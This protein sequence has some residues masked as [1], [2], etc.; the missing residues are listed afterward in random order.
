MSLLKPAPSAGGVWGSITGTLSDQTDLQSALNA[1]VS[2]S[3]VSGQVAYFNGTGSITGNANMTF[4]GTTLTAAAV[5]AAYA[6]AGPK[7]FV[8]NT[9]PSGASFAGGA[10]SSLAY[11][12]FPSSK[13]FMLAP[14]SD[15][16]TSP[17]SSDA[18][19]AVDSTSVYIGAYAT[20]AGEPLIVRGHIGMQDNGAGAAAE[21]RFYEPSAGGTNYVGFKA[22]ALTANKVWT[23]PSADGTSGQALTTNGSGALSFATVTSPPG[24]SSGEVQYNNAG[25]FGGITGSAVSG[26]TVTFDQM[27]LTSQVVY[28]GPSGTDGSWRLRVSGT[29][30][31]VER[32]ESS[33]WVEKGSYLS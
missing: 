32:R 6:G 17:S 5:N 8:R 22:P 11:L 23:L 30:L 7:L 12:Q 20:L 18:K 28:L 33:S 26:S 4:D 13:V 19:L 9:S 16:T 1:K 25:A 27:V 10:G 2:G 31:L 21:L 29:S 3:G 24:G 15:I 14:V